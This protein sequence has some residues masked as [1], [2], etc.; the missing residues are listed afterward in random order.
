NLMATDSSGRVLLQPTQTGVTIPTVTAV[1]NTVTATVSG[2]VTVGAYAAGEDPA[3]LLFV[4]PANK[5]ATDTSG[6]VL[7]QPAQAGVTIPTVTTL[8]NIATANVTQWGSNAVPATHV[9]GVPI[10]DIGY[11][12]GTT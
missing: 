11:V 1:T 6:R 2:S 5:L 3:T 10:V 4:T 12:L 9:N 8:T 7:L